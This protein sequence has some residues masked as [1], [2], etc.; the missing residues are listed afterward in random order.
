M[1]RDLIK[2][3]DDW[4]FFKIQKYIIPSIVFLNSKKII[5]SLTKEEIKEKIM[6]ICFTRNYNEY[7]NENK[8]L[9][10]GIHVENE[11]CQ[12][13]LL[14]EHIENA[15]VKYWNCHYWKHFTLQ[16]SIIRT[17]VFDIVGKFEDKGFFEGQYAKRYYELGFRTCFFDDISTEHIGKKLE[18]NEGSN[19]YQLNSLEQF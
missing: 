9:L 1:F 18:S 2:S 17:S 7:P 8:I 16:P 6:Q 12:K 14:H 13:Y 10:G 5:N 3:E 19:A 11:K 15:N 4:S